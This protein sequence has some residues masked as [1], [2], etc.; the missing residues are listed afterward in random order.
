MV[1]ECT[2]NPGDR[3]SSPNCIN[4]MASA[5]LAGQGSLRTLPPLQLPLPHLSGGPP[6]AA[7]SKG[8]A[9]ANRRSPDLIK[10]D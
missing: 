4:A 8:L 1:E 9:D 5:R 7:S 3:A 10:E 6:E 2:N